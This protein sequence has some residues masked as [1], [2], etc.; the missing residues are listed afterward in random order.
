[1]VYQGISQPIRAFTRSMSAFGARDTNARVVSRAFRWARCA[2]CRPT[3][4]SRCRHARASRTRR[5]RRRRGK[6]LTDGGRRTGRAGS[7]CPWAR[8]IRTP[9]P[10]PATASADAWRPARHGRGSTPSPSQAVAGAQ[11]PTPAVTRFWGVSFRSLSFRVPSLSVSFRFPLIRFV[12]SPI[13]KFVRG[14]GDQAAARGG[15]GRDQR[16]IGD[17]YRAHRVISPPSHVTIRWFFPERR[18]T[19][20]AIPPRICGILPPTARPL[21]MVWLPIAFH[22]RGHTAGVEA[23]LPFPGRGDALKSRAATWR[24]GGLNG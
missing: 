10:R 13:M 20:R 4:S 1:M 9:S 24:R 18:P 5:A 15:A 7:P 22:E 21:S 16:E 8:R 3:W 19:D 6:R 17:A 12:L 11:P 14:K 2:T 23:G